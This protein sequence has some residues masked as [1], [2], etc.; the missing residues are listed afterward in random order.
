M[1]LENCYEIFGVDIKNNA[2][3]NKISFLFAKKTVHIFKYLLQFFEK[4]APN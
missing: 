1:H 4:S 3:V 2:L